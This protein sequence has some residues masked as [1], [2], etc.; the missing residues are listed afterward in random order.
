M[1][2]QLTAAAAGATRQVN[3]PPPVGT[4]NPRVL[5]SS[6]PTPEGPCVG[7]ER[8]AGLGQALPTGSQI[9]GP[10]VSHVQ[11]GATNIIT[12][13]W[14]AVPLVATADV[15]PFCHLRDCFSAFAPSHLCSVARVDQFL[16]ERNF[17]YTC[18]PPTKLMKCGYPGTS[19]SCGV[20]RVHSAVCFW[21]GFPFI[22]SSTS[23]NVDYD[24]L[25]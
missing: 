22:Y 18:V 1:P 2:Q 16:C 21:V 4:R 10:S 3:K 13:V 25:R 6:E 7:E 15:C 11:G 24:A 20:I 19:Y 5:D 9:V 23:E 12:P 8:R 17:I 14:G